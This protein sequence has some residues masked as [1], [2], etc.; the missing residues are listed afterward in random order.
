MEKKL[1]RWSIDYCDRRGGYHHTEYGVV[2]AE[3][4]EQAEAKVWDWGKSDYAYNLVIAEVD[5]LDSVIAF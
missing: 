2:F 5:D 3:T 1:F 4:I